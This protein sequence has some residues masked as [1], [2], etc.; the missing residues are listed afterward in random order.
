MVTPKTNNSS[1]PT[2]ALERM[3][4]LL[5]QA[6][7]VGQMGAWEV[8]AVAQ[9][10]TWSPQLQ[11]LLGIR[12]S[13]VRSIEESYAFYADASRAIVREAFDA[14]I[15]RGTPYDIE[16]QMIT[17]NGR[18]IWVREV[19]QPT[20][21]R[22]RVASIV[23]VIQDISERRRMADLL[24]R[25]ADEERARIG[26]D[27][28]DGLGQEL[29]G[30]SLLLQSVA[31]QAARDCPSLA[32][33][34]AALSK[35][36]GRTVQSVRDLSHAMLPL[37]IKERG[38]KRVFQELATTMRRNLQVGI[39]LRFVG[40]ERLLPE[41][42]AAEH[43]YRI[44]Q[45]SIANAVKHGRARCVGITVDGSES[46]IVLTVLDDGRGFDTQR[47]GDGRGLQIMR[48]RSR[49]LGGFLHV[50]P[51][52]RGGTRVRCIVPRSNP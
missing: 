25:S 16:L 35:M 43:L 45:E 22:G 3:H 17:G 28:H 33:E 11:R 49:L 15:L 36:A 40:A 8:D 13:P 19:C 31:A 48:Y 29:T 32:M 38:F 52:A 27:L 18:L 23:G 4:R 26:A 46:K 37:E 6:E 34:L 10:V 39:Q 47:T 20:M 9:Q 12:G 21:R 42:P 24:A 5:A 7:R 1:S 50:D 2:A 14:A 44:A 51:R 30:L 41:G